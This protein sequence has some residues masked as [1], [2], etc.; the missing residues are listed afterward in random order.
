[1]GRCNVL[2]WTVHVVQATYFVNMGVFSQSKI[3]ESA[4]DLVTALSH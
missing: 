3:P 4:A 1:M 2:K